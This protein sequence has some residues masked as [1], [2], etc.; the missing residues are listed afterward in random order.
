[1]PQSYFDSKFVFGENFVFP[2]AFELGILKSQVKISTKLKKKNLLWITRYFRLSV[3]TLSG[4]IP[5][6]REYAVFEFSNNYFEMHFQIHEKV[7]INC[8]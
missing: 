3:P 1:M 7:Q 2:Y 6:N 5:D 4:T 8:Q